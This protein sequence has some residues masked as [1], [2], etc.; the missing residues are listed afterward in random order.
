MR[1][2]YR[3]RRGYS[4]ARRRPR[5]DWLVYQNSRIATDNSVNYTNLIDDSI[6]AGAD[7]NYPP[8]VTVVG[9]RISVVVQTK[10][11]ATTNAIHTCRFGLA[12]AEV[13]V[14]E[15]PVANLT[16]SSE[17]FESKQWLWT[18]YGA[19]PSTYAGGPNG[20][21]F[22]T[23]QIRTKRIVPQNKALVWIDQLYDSSDWVTIYL[24]LLVKV[25]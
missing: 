12:V 2:S 25:G 3:G 22:I 8:E 11:A 15:L 10:A 16:T 13:A 18:H 21:A 23:H 14:D 17:G 9:G 1:A 24:R 20:S 19:V 6:K 7:Y 5:Y 4:R